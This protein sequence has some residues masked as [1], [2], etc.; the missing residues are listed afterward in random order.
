MPIVLESHGWVHYEKTTR[1]PAVD[2]TQQRG[3]T[4]KPCDGLGESGVK[5]ANF[6]ESYCRLNKHSGLG[7]EKLASSQ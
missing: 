5:G 4:L 7:L 1:W 3:L 2:Q 6:P